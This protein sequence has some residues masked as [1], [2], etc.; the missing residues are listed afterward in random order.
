MLYVRT[1]NLAGLDPGILD[2]T[3]INKRLN[4]MFREITTRGKWQL[5]Q[6]RPVEL[7]KTS[8]LTVR[9]SRRALIQKLCGFGLV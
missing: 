9:S 8:I 5:Y 7:V 4:D 1:L 3:G 6:F 2:L